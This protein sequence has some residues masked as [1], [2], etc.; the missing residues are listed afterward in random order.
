M[1]ERIDFL[2]GALEI[3]SSLGRGTRL[4]ARVPI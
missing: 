2:G 3:E 4:T 1:R